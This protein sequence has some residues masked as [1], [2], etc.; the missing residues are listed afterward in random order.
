MAIKI[1]FMIIYFAVLIAVGIYYRRHTSDVSSFVMGGRSIG[2]IFSAFAFGTTYFSAVVFVGFAGQFGWRY[3]IGA[4]WIGLG[5][6]FIG[7]MLS[8]VVLAR[9]TR[10]MSQHLGSATMPEFFKIRYK[11]NGLKI[12]AACIAFIFMIP[13]AASLFNGL[14]RLFAMA[15][16]I[17]FR[18]VVVI[19]SIITAVYVI[20]GGYMA[21]AFNDFFQ[22]MV[23]LVGIFLVIGTFLGGYGGLTGAMTA[24]ANVPNVVTDNLTANP[25]LGEPG[26]FASMFG[27][28]PV[29]LLG[30]V[31][32]T[33]LGTW[34]LP[35]MVHK[36]YAI[37]SE[38][39]IGKGTIF[40]TLFC[41][42]FAGGA[43]F[44]GG[45]GR[46]TTGVVATKPDGSIIF[47]SIVP[48]MMSKFSDPLIAIVIVMVMSASISTLAAVTMSSASTFTLNLLNNKGTMN[49]KSKVSSMRI[50]IALFI[51]ASGVIAVLQ[52]TFNFAFIAQLMGS[53]WGAISGA[54]LGPFVYGLYWKRTTKVACI[55]NMC[56]AAVFTVL[57]FFS[58]PA[59]GILPAETFP[60]ILRSPI[61]AGA[62]TM[63]FGLILVPLLSL[64]TKAPDKEHVDHCFTC[65]STESVPE[66]EA[67]SV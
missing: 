11:S 6:A 37:K 19:M 5:N 31:I 18:M 51:I 8:W 7:A 9:R 48:A 13:Y 4:F 36:Y 30:V 61:N 2:P 27:P 50:L 66:I 49:E 26:I 29:N 40:T 12:L 58:N 42:V 55:I 44:L 17:D 56:F 22:G 45:F 34:G 25:T 41:I 57:V 1:I 14:S 38:K 54:F 60:A 28:D 23:M 43:Y 64:I 16:D 67:K 21:T 10:L 35:Q 47:D 24:L 33:S 62:F 46:L 39:V 59:I 15:F 32:L 65:L 53:A 63:I 52:F 3:G 20:V